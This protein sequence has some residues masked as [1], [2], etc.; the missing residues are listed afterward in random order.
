MAIPE[1][2]LQAFIQMLAA[3]QAQHI[4]M[5]GGVQRQFQEAM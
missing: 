3:Q 5:M 1:A 4:D 2:M